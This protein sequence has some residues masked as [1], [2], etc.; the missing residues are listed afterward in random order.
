[1]SDQV[2]DFLHKAEAV[3]NPPDLPAPEQVEA[4]P[5]VPFQSALKLTAD[6]ERTMID[7]AFK[8]F[9]TLQT[10]L[11][12]DVTIQ[13]NWWTNQPSQSGNMALASQG[14]LPSETFLGKRCRFDAMFNNDVSWRPWT[15]PQP[16]IF[17]SSNLSVPLVRRIA[18]QMIARAK[19]SF[20]G[21]EPWFNVDPAPVPEFD[22]VNDADRADAIEKFTRFK[23]RESGSKADKEEAIS[24]AL[25][26]GECAVKTSYVVRDQIFNFE[27]R[28]LVDV[29]GQPVRAS[30]GNHITEGEEFVD[31]VDELGQASRVLKRDGATPE[32]LAPIWQ[33]VPLNRRQVLFEGARSEVIYYKDFLMPITATDVQS[34]DTVIHCYDKP[35]MAFVDLLVKRGMVGDDTEARMEGGRKLVACVKAL[36]NNSPQ[37]KA[38][39]TQSARPGEYF[40]TPPSTE[41]GGPVAEFL[42][43]YLW[44]DANGDGIAENIML[45]C[46]RN[47]QAPIYYEHV[48]NVTTDGLRPIEIVRINPVAGRWYGKGVC[49]LFEPYQTIVDLQV[50][51]WNYNNAASGRIV[52]TKPSQTLE[53]EGQPGFSMD[54]GKAYTARPTANLEDIVKVVYLSDIKFSEIQTMLQF[55]LQLCMNESGV[56]NANDDQAAGMQSAK[57]ATGVL[58]VAKSGDELFKPLVADLQPCIERVV[59]REIDVTLANINPQEAYDYLEGNDQKIG[60]ITPDEV[61]G[62]KYKC[63]ITLST[64]RTEEKIRVSTQVVALIEKF[65]TLLPMVQ[66]YVAPE[67]RKQIRALDPT[68]DVDTVIVALPVQQTAAPGGGAE[69]GGTPFEA[70]LGQ[71]DNQMEGVSA[72]GGTMAAA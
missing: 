35:V 56:S 58:E 1:M 9:R 50:N 41:T 20:F 40:N 36:S 10:E 63:V 13:P 70:Q 59:N 61:R 14:L 39:V 21:A 69:G 25:I 24:A 4:Q 2:G 47:T 28:V 38:A 71:Q 46:D 34:A 64:H 32:P 8:R 15:T 65:Y 16:N 5:K 57:L 43:F 51:R 7:H 55:W 33:N 11:G 31:S 6:Q 49:E 60:L 12:R 26:L 45:I 27:A 54:F 66:Q 30:D 29:E 62:L 44:F 3:V 18:R 52:L 22:P 42:E 72:P 53:G 19:N 17:M 48:A 23:L 67:I 37:P 68:V